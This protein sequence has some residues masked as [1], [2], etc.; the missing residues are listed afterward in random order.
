ML[1]EVSLDETAI[2]FTETDLTHEHKFVFI[3]MDFE[4]GNGDVLEAGY[5]HRLTGY[6]FNTGVIKV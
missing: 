2:V 3:P 4:I 1:K 5:D 6:V